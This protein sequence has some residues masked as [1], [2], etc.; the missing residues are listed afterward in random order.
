MTPVKYKI[1]E[2]SIPSI[3]SF[4]VSNELSIDALNNIIDMVTNAAMFDGDIVLEV[5]YSS[6]DNHWLDIPPPPF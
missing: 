3:T 2:G 1:S 5:K 6:K 4:K